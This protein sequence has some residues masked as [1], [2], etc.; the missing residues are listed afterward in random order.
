MEPEEYPVYGTI[1]SRFADDGVNGLYK[2]LA[3]KLNAKLKEKHFHVP[4]L[5]KFSHE[6]T[7]RDALIPNDRIN[8]LAEVAKSVRHY[9]SSVRQQVEAVRLAE[10]FDLV[11]A[12][13]KD[14]ALAAD[15]DAAWAKV[16]AEN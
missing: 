5:Y 15:G 1:A 6:S 10:A 16:A 8:Y 11:R 7:N 13:K 3:D 9:H 12:S 14:Q 2:A 4:A